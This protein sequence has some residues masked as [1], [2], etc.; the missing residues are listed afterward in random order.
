[1][2]GTPWLVEFPVYHPHLLVGRSGVL[3][4]PQ[5]FLDAIYRMPDG[6]LTLVDY[7]SLMQARPPNYRLRDLKNLRQ[8]VTNAAYFQAA[9]K[10]RLQRASLVY[11]TRMGTVT[12]VTLDLGA[13][14]AVTKAALLT[15]LAKATHRITYDSTRYAVG[16][17]LK[18]QTIDDL[19]DAA[20]G[21]VAG[22]PI[23]PALRPAAPATPAPAQAPQA[24]AAAEQED[25]DGSP[26]PPRRR[27]SRRLQQPSSDDEEGAGQPVVGAMYTTDAEAVATAVVDEDAPAA[28]SG[29]DGTLAERRAINERLADAAEAVF[30]QLPS[31]NK[32]KLRGRTGELFQY[33]AAS[34]TLFPQ[35]PTADGGVAPSPPAVL[36]PADA[37]PL[38]VQALIR[39]AQRSL[40]QAVARKFLRTRAERARAEVA[41]GVP[42]ESFLSELAHHSRRDLWTQEALE[43]AEGALD[44]VV[45]ALAD[46][47]AVFLAGV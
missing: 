23:P 38:A 44:G 6:S 39:T 29:I 36:I 24:Q 1:M 40:N 25:E 42:L 26:P 9:T 19:L 4:C 21:G 8:I 16:Q 2:E 32:I 28:A 10:I 12:V 47:V 31:S 7:K 27:R 37:R 35:L 3:K 5:T 11:I 22:S 17:Q 30:D 14:G 41:D 33:L 45:S 43:F 18:V 46:E 34:R 15:P 13:C 20:V